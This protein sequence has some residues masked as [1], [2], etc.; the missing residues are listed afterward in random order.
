M[1]LLYRI[2]LC[3]LLVLWVVVALALTAA[4]TKEWQLRNHRGGSHLGC[5][6]A[7]RMRA[8]RNA[9]NRSVPVQAEMGEVRMWTVWKHPLVRWGLVVVLLFATGAFIVATT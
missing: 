5:A 1:V 7:V 9:M 8:K 2:D 3:D 4:E 6:V